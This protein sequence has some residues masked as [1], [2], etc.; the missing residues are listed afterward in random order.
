[1]A[2]K[3]ICPNCHNSLREEGDDCKSGA[4]Y[5]VYD[6]LWNCKHQAGAFRRIE[7]LAC[8]HIGEVGAFEV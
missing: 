7:C 6:S 2:H 8:L 1:M 4:E 5:R 3:L